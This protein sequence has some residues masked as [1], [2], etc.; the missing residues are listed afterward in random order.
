MTLE[1]LRPQIH[2]A[3]VG[4]GDYS[5]QGTIDVRMRYMLCD[6]RD[7]LSRTATI[8]LT[9]VENLI[10]QQLT[11]LRSGTDT[12]EIGGELDIAFDEKQRAY[13]ALHAHREEHG[14]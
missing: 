4:Q 8:S 14:C 6:R 11:G 1:S 9:N 3:R 2:S 13:D 5:D 10:K 7:N 12:A